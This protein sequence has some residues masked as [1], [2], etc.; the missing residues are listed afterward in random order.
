ML[1]IVTA[2]MRGSGVVDCDRE[3]VRDEIQLPPQRCGI[4]PNS[5]R[6]AEPE[7]RIGFLSDSSKAALIARYPFAA[8]ARSPL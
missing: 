3:S 8:A 1:P 6:Q 2:M 5:I 4:A 7:F